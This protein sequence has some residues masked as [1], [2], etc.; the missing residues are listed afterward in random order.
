[1]AAM[2]INEA[3]AAWAQAM[4][5]A[6]QAWASACAEQFRQE[7][8]ALDEIADEVNPKIGNTLSIRN[9]EA[10][11]IIDDWKAYVDGNETSDAVRLVVGASTED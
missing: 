6:A 4:A 3:S 8:R 1:M 2:S 11:Q 9:P 5:E 7:Q 10:E